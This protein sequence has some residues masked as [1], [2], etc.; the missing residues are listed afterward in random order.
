MSV[1]SMV[2]G[3]LLHTTERGATMKREPLRKMMAIAIAETLRGTHTW[4]VPNAK[5]YVNRSRLADYCIRMDTELDSSDWSGALTILKK[6][7]RQSNN[8][9]RFRYAP[10]GTP[11]FYLRREIIRELEL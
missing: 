8:P 5:R 7:M 1:L 3:D 2:D 6:A 10:E 9:V 11:T 4:T